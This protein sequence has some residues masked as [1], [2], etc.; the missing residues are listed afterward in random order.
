[1]SKLGKKSDAMKFTSVNINDFLMSV[2]KTVK[3][4][5]MQKKVE[6]VYE[7]FR[8]VTADIDA[9]KLTQAFLNLIENAVKYNKEGGTVQVSLDAD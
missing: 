8:D 3:P 1:M 6:V 2:L 9:P 4:I 7:S 5:A